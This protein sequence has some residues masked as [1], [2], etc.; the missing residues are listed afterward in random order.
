MKHRLA[1]A[2]ALMALVAPLAAA[3]D[4]PTRDTNMSA[5]E[6]TLA[7]PRPL[8]PGEPA[9]L[10]VQ[11]GPISRGRVITITSATGHPLGTISPFGARVGEAGGT[12]TLPVPPDAIRDG[13][14][15]VR[16][17]ISQGGGPPRAPTAE[18]V[19]GVKLN[20]SNGPR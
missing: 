10:E 4:G 19:R 18:E 15:T 17:T 5:Q 16:L 14:L 9:W 7:L 13:K 6:L 1:A 8:R 3:Q 2:V 11:V 20:V 12:Y